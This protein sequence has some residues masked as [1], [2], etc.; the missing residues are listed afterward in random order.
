[1]D[2]PFQGAAWSALHTHLPFFAALLFSLPPVSFVLIKVGLAARSAS[3][4]KVTKQWHVTR[5]Q[6]HDLNSLSSVSDERT[7]NSSDERLNR[8]VENI[9]RSAEVT[10][11]QEVP[12]T[13]ESVII[14]G[15]SEATCA[16]EAAGESE[17][18]FE[19]VEADSTDKLAEINALVEAFESEAVVEAIEIEAAVEPVETDATLEEVETPAIPFVPARPCR[20]R[21]PSS[22][23]SRLRVRGRRRAD[24]YRLQ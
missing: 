3:K 19:F 5:D 9:L 11:T 6:D 4:Q 14:Q 8:A 13:A 1:M 24:S 12:E 15:E 20:Q 23:T 10:P 7:R 16:S 21:R 17:A 2:T 18:T 22:Q